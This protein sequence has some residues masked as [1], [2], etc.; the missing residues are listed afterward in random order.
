[1]ITT[2][3]GRPIPKAIASHLSLVYLVDEGHRGFDDLFVAEDYTVP[4]GAVNNPVALLNVR[5]RAALE[6]A[7]EL[8][9]VDHPDRVRGESLSAEF[10]VFG[11]RRDVTARH[12]APSASPAAGRE[13][14][15]PRRRLAR[16]PRPFVC[17]GRFAGSDRATSSSSCKRS[18]V[19]AS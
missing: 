19:H 18:R 5:A 11:A 1:P 7:I 4:R 9:I 14:R 8:A 16:S 17:T 2:S 15:P 13:T 10:G 3:S 6:Q 12:A